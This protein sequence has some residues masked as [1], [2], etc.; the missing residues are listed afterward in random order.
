MLCTQFPNCTL[1]KYK[2]T[3]DDVMIQHARKGCM[4]G[5][6]L[7]GIKDTDDAK[8]LANDIVKHDKLQR[9]Y[10]LSGEVGKAYDVLV[11]VLAEVSMPP[12]S[13]TNL[14]VEKGPKNIHF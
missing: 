3:S 7:A 5:F 14:K 2:L 1:N 8:S 13:A 10:L 12:I 11:Q 9:K 6:G 4:R